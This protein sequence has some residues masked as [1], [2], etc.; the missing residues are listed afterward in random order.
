MKNYSPRVMIILQQQK[1]I[2][3]IFYEKAMLHEC[4]EYEIDNINRTFITYINLD[5]TWK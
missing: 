5:Q 3:S 4:M 1:D 2:E